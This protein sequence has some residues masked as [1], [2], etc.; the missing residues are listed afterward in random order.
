[1]KKLTF[2]LAFVFSC[3]VGASAQPRMIEKKTAETKPPVALANAVFKAKYEG[4]LF[5]FSEK[6]EG[7]L[8]FDDA[9][10]R[11]VFFDKTNKELFG[12]PY[13]AIMVVYPQSQTVQTT[14]GKVVQHIPLPGAGLAGAFIREKRRFLIIN[15]DDREMDAKGTANF[16]LENKELLDSLI[17]AIGSKAE[18]QQ[19]GD[20]YYRPRRVGVQPQ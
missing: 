12:I 4:G 15:Y 8:R 14:G 2:F 10:L 19:R 9:N 11:L 6:A 1:M 13:D 5:G 18:M 7:S 3:V 20:A 16:K 17:Q